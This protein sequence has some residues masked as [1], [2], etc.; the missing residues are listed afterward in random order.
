M[1]DRFY[2]SGWKILIISAVFRFW[3][4]KIQLIN[5]YN[6]CRKKSLLKLLTTDLKRLWFIILQQIWYVVSVEDFKTLTS[7]VLWYS[8]VTAMVARGQKLQVSSTVTAASKIV[9]ICA[10]WNE[11]INDVLRNLLLQTFLFPEGSLWSITD[12]MRQLF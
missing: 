11:V 8:S 3:H 2:T 7:P 5:A 4:N 12:V 1:C 6:Q 10:C 9:S